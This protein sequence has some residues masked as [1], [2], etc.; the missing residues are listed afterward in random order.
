MTTKYNENTVTGTT[1]RIGKGQEKT[2]NISTSKRYGGTRGK[3]N[4]NNKIFIF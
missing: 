3:Y 4:N 1:R 2:K